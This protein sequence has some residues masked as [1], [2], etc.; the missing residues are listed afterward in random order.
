MKK[1]LQRDV[2]LSGWHIK[3]LTILVAAFIS[4]N[5]YSQSMSSS[6]VANSDGCSWPWSALS[7]HPISNLIYGIWEKNSTYTIFRW[8]ADGTSRTAVGTFTAS[9]VG[10]AVGRGSSW[11]A[12]D[13]VD[14]EIG[15]DGSIHVVFRMGAISNQCCGQRR[16]VFYGKST[17]GGSS[18]SFTEIQ[19]YTDP[20]GWKNTDEPILALDLLNR[21]HVAFVYS[22]ANT[23]RT[24]ALRYRSFNGTSWNALE[25]PFSQSGA[26]NEI[27]EMGMD[28]DATGAVHIAFQRETN[29][30]GCDGGLWY[31]KKISSWSTPQ[32]LRAGAGNCSNRLVQGYSP[33]VQTGP[34]NQV[35][36][37]SY[38]YQ[39]KI[40]LT[41]NA[42]GSWVS[43]QVSNL[44]GS[45]SPH[46]FTMNAN[47]DKF[48]MYN[49]NNKVRFA[50]QAVG[51]NTWSTG[52]AYTSNAGGPPF[53]GTINNQRQAMGLVDFRPAGSCG[54]SNPR[55]LFQTTG[56]VGPGPPPPP[57]C[58]NPTVPTVSVSSG[59]CPSS[60]RTLTIASGS[61]NDAT[62]WK[63]Y[64]GSCGGTLV[65]TG[66]S[67]SVSPSSTTTYYV[68]G[69][70]GCVT[71][72]T[73]RSVSVTVSDNIDPGIVCPSNI[74]LNTAAGLCGRSVAYSLPTA[75]DNCSS[76]SLARLTGPASGAFFAKGT[77]VVTY[78]ATDGSGNTATCSF[79]VTIVDNILPTI[80]CPSNIAVANDQGQCGAVVTYTLPTASDNCTGVSLSRTAGLASGSFFPVGTSTVSY[81]ATDAAGNEAACSFTVTV[82]DSELPTVTCSSSINVGSDPGIC[83]AVVNYS[84]PSFSDNCPG[85]S[86]IQTSGIASGSLFPIGTTTN[87]FK[88]TDAAGNMSTC[89][90]TVIVN[91]SEAPTISCPANITV[92]NDPGVCGASVTYVTTASDNCPGINVSQTLGLASGA[93]YPIGTTTNT[94][95]VTDAAGNMASCSFTVTV[96]DSEAPTIVCPTNIAENNDPGQC[97]AVVTYSVTGAD[98]CPGESILQTAGMASGSQFPIGTTTNT[99]V[100]TDAAGNTGTCSF[101]VVI[102]DNE[103]PTVVCSAPIS[104]PNDLGECGAIVNFTN[105][106]ADNCPGVTVVSSPASGTQFPVG[107]TTV[108]TVATDLAGNQETCTFTVA[109]NDTED[110]MITCP[111]NQTLVADNNCQVVYSGPPASFTDNCPGAKV[112]SSPALPATF[113]G[114][115]IHAIVYTATDM[116]G[117]TTV[118]TQTIEVISSIVPDAGLDDVVLINTGSGPS[119]KPCV[120]LSASATGGAGGYSY[121][122]SPT[123]GLS[124]PNV[125]NPTACPTTTTTYTVTIVDA[126]GCFETDE[127]TVLVVDINDPNLPQVGNNQNKI[128]ACDL[129]TCTTLQLNKNA[130]CSSPNSLCYWLN[131]G[132]VLGECNCKSQ[133]QVDQVSL[134]DVYPNPANERTSLDVMLTHTQD[135]S[136]NIYDYKGSIVAKVH[137]GELIGG[138]PVKFELNTSTYAS[139]VYLITLRTKEEVKY[140]KL[141]KRN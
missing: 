15:N 117:N 99:F 132:A 93:T 89:I 50:F 75:T 111:A 46:S 104:V 78:R 90:S 20:N 131:Q 36:I 130:N 107:I 133:Q 19:T 44:T 106:A 136:I 66:T 49:S 1:N 29:G 61:L 25:T 76:V 96:N 7:T 33:N 95:I 62:A 103:K 53:A 91:D 98:N 87:A 54:N 109:V 18:F 77:T 112:T 28:V 122:W 63:W 47:S 35:Y 124:D 101:D 41:T 58:T 24:Y 51:T 39:G 86:I 60:S 119:P 137:S 5:V 42:S 59:T 123:T 116:A 74:V 140:L 100:I 129:N 105:T 84:L 83:G 13:D 92:N 3:L 23:P 43:N 22:E 16:G 30:T 69:E 120:Q 97:G 12:S 37:L 57:P 56:F 55:K 45:L 34:G 68:R 102:S 127:V 79:T 126:G 82:N 135:V 70:G 65:G 141:I 67:I 11:G 115:G 9:S 26:S 80:T 134:L 17:N 139:G 27:T 88:V 108:T 73:C 4:A 94:F 81:K 32:V 48:I 138:V 31:T 6:F 128:Y 38:N 114:Q 64:S 85:A 10:Q 121:S 125:A 110:P 113:S 8:N 14:I 40:N 2:N 21:P 118:C 52:D 71:A 72:G